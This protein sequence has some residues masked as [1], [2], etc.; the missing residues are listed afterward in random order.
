MSKAVKVAPSQSSMVLADDI[1]SRNQVTSQL[2]PWLEYGWGEKQ[3]VAHMI[4]CGWE[5]GTMLAKGYIER[6]EVP[7]PAIPTPPAPDEYVEKA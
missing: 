2:D 6:I 7:G 4:D 5:E 3:L 1:L